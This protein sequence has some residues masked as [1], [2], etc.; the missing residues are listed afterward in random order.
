MTNRELLNKGIKY[1]AW[2]LPAL[3][4]GPTLIHFAFI[5]KKQP[6]FPLIIGIGIVICITGVVLSFKGIKTMV[7]G[8]FND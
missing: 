1:L 2:A 3:F 5:N 7:K 8:L 4:I 6:L